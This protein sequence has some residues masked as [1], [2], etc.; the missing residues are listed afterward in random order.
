[1]KSCPRI[2]V[3]MAVRRSKVFGSMPETRWGMQKMAN[4]RC[5]AQDRTREATIERFAGE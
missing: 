3:E 4:D 1:M 5:R 2:Y